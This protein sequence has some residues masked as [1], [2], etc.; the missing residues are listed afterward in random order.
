V[1][2]YAGCI[3]RNESSVHGHE[4]FKINHLSYCTNTQCMVFSNYI[5]HF[6]IVSGKWCAWMTWVVIIFHS[7]PAFQKSF[8]PFKNMWTRHTVFTVSLSQ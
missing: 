4:S 2:I 3:S 5:S 8:V 7:F 6:F 1:H